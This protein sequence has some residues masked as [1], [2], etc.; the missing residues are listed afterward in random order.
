MRSSLSACIGSSIAQLY[1]HW[2]LPAAALTYLSPMSRP[3]SSLARRA[4][5][6]GFAPWIASCAAN[7]RTA[8]PAESFDLVVAATTDVHGRLTGWDYYAGGADSLR[9]LSRAA[10]IVDS[11]RTAN[12]DRVVLVDAGDLLQGNPL[13]FVGARVDTTR[14]HPVIAAM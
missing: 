1:H 9:G 11:V 6:F 4:L 7:R 5:L 14:P 2:I 8:R 12:P 10:T 13:A 3:V